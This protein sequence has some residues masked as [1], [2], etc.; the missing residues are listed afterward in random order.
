LCL[1]S[2]RVSALAVRFT[3]STATAL[4]AIA[5]TTG[6]NAVAGSGGHATDPCR[7]T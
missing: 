4:A 6:P 1:R 2:C 5:A 7:G 3:S